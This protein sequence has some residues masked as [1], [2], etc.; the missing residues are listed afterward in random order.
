MPLL[1]NRSSHE[2]ASVKAPSLLMLCTEPPRALIELSAGLMLRNSLLKAA[3]HGDGHAL[4]V[5][6]G[7]GASDLSTGMLRRFLSDLGYEAHGWEQG[8]NTGARL[9]LEQR[10]RERLREIH[11]E[12]GRKVSLIGHSL[13]GLY[14]RELAKLEPDCVRQVISLGSPFAGHLG[15][16]NA[17]RLYEWLSGEQLKDIA[18]EQVARVLAKPPVP[19]TSVYSKTDGIVAW[20]CSIEGDNNDGESIHLRAASHL[21]MTACPSALYLVAERLAQ[22]EGHWQ[23]FAPTGWQRLVYGVQDHLPAALQPLPA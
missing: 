10:M 8:R 22:P 19:T 7:L 14:A 5:L 23:A 4:M 9:G 17:T 16:T 3:P 2:H 1:V 15:S 12:T 6:P 21:G 11:T 13:G 20:P 18:P